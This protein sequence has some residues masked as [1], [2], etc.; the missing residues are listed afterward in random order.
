[1]NDKI[2]ISTISKIYFVIVSFLSFIFLT[3]SVIFVLLQNG[4]YIDNISLPNLKIKKLYIKWNE[5]LSI[6]VDETKIIKKKSNNTA[7][8]YKEINKIFKELVLFD[9]WFEQVIINKITF[10]EISASFKYIDGKNGFIKALS[11]NFSLKSS[12]FF[13]SKLLNIKIDEFHDFKKKIDLSGNIIFDAY[14]LELT[15][16]LNANINN[17]VFLNILLNANRDRLFYRVNSLKDIKSI[18]HTVDIFNL[19]PRVR[20]WIVDAIKMSDLSLNAAYG[21]MDYKNLGQAYKNFYADAT[22]NKLHYTYDQALDAI[23]TK[24]TAIEFREGVLYIRPHKAY[25]YGFFMDKSWLKIDFTTKEELLTLYLL[26]EGKVNQDLLGLLNRYEIKLPFLQNSGTVDTNL[27]LTVNLMTIDV[28]AKGN[29]F[30]KE[31]N[32]NYL[33]LD[34]DIFDAYITLNNFDVK[35]ENML[36]KYQDIATAKVNVTFDA[37]NKIGDIDFKVKDISFKETGLILANQKDLNISYHISPKQDTIDIDP[38]TWN[39]QEQAIEIDR[40]KVPFNLDKLTAKIPTTLVKIPNRASAYISGMTS[41]KPNR[42][43]LNIDLLKLSFENLELTQSNTALKLL[44]E[45]K[46]LNIKSVDEV[47]INIDDFE[48]II[49]NLS[50]NIENEN[51]F[52]HKANFN[53][54]NIA[55]TEINGFYNSAIKK[56]SINLKNLKIRHNEL[57]EYIT[58]KENLHLVINLNDKETMLT[59]KELDMDY[60]Q[61]NKGWKLRFNSLEKLA[62]QSKKLK[63]YRLN[64]GNLTIYKNIKDSDMKILS[65]IKYPYKLLVTNNK[66]VENYIINGKIDNKTGGVFLNINNS[67]DIEIDKSLKVDAKEVGVNIN[68]ILDFFNDKNSTQNSTKNKSVMLN[69]KNSYLWISKNRHIISDTIELQYFNNITT[70]QLIHKKGNAGFK[71]ENYNFHLYGEKFGDDFMD[72]LFALSD[73]KDGEL[74]FSIDGTTKEYD[75]IFHIKNTTIIDYKILNNILAFIN[76]VPSLVTF[77]LPGYSKDGLRVKR[78]YMNFHSKDDTIDISDISLNSEEIDIVGYGKASFQRNDIDLQLNL[79]SDL[80]SSVA[81]IPLVGYILLGKD[82]VSTSLSVT[83]ALDDPDVNTLI[84]KDIIVAPLNIIKRTFTLPFQL[85]SNDKDK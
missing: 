62:Q 51:I 44:Y 71:F 78:A 34:I 61:E 75:G 67:I 81:K 10:N 4:I 9:N 16:S 80:G 52:L 72:S 77:S 68:A 53:L 54:Q 12:L 79:K 46:K 45:N 20:Y 43:D 26:F 35:I 83:G 41:L 60:T 29:F 8:D 13:E 47:R 33:G 24:N 42:V 59:I 82:T 56:G 76:T 85:F 7:I 37:K 6:T 49:S 69:L 74:V 14:N 65:N 40:L 55:N 2:V 38:S 19:D 23:H 73:F 50:I 28:Q 63:E 22:L 17:E 48:S 36:A 1:M 27:K 64:S 25:T 18:T 30:T 5:K 21:W 58:E 3:L 32:F 84:A 31:A 66:P 11:P 70:A 39:F 15:S 57:K